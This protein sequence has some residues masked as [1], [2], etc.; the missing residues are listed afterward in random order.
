MRL[1]RLGANLKNSVYMKQFP[2]IVAYAVTVHKCQGLSLDCAI[3]DL[4]DAVF[5]AG[6]AYVA[7]SRVRTLDSLHL[8]ASDPKSIMVSVKCLSE[9]NRLQQ[10]YRKDLLTY[11]IPALKQKKDQCHVYHWTSLRPMPVG[12]VENWYCLL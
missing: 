3:V 2:L 11:D 7:L 9:I 12:K 4:T 8:I 10:L 5:C 6:M 1:R